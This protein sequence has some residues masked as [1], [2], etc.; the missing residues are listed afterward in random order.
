MTLYIIMYYPAVRHQVKWLENA[1]SCLLL[2][3]STL[4]HYQSQQDKT[5]ET[6]GED[7]EE[8]SKQSHGESREDVDRESRG[9]ESRGG[10]SEEDE[11]EEEECDPLISLLLRRLLGVLK[12][13]VASA[14]KKRYNYTLRY[15][16]YSGT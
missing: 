15:P 16:C 3:E 6:S 2:C 4:Q 9:R 7:G 8:G 11:D 5:K 13:L 14:M 12:Q 1:L 10:Q